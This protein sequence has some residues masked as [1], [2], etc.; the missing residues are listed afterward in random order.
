MSPIANPQFEPPNNDEL[1]AYLDGELPPEEC[2]AVEE[3]L[4]N[5]SS[6][7]QQL[8]DLDQAWE[9]LSSLPPA[10]V[11]DSFA[12]TTIE[13]ACVQ[14]QDDISRQKSLVA[15]ETGSRRRWWIAGGVAAAL[16][17]F[18]MARAIATHRSNM[19]L[20]DLPLIQQ[21]NVLSHVENIAFLRQLAKDVPLAELKKD[22]DD[23][24]FQHDL[25]SFRK[26]NALPLAGRREWVNSL[27]ADEKAALAERSRLFES[28]AQT[29]A[30]RDRWREL[31]HEASRDPQLEET[32]VAYGQW[33]G[34]QSGAQLEQLRENTKDLQTDE[35]VAEVHRMVHDESVQAAKHLSPPDAK[36]LRDEIFAL[37]K[38][39]KSDVLNKIPERERNRVPDFDVSKPAGATFVVR[40]L[41]WDN[42]TRATT[43]DRLLS[44]LSPEARDHWNQLGLGGRMRQLWQWEVDALDPQLGPAELEQFFASDLTP[45]EQQMLL[46][47]PRSEMKSRLQQMYM[48]S[49]LGIDDDRAQFF[50][51]FGEGLRGPGPPNR[52]RPGERGPGPGFDFGPGGP[53][54]PGDPRF[55]RGRPEGE[56]RPDGRR[57][58]RPENRMDDGRRG[59][60]RHRPPDDGPDGPPHG[61][62][63][64][65]PPPDDQHDPP[66]T[67]V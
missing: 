30:D 65:G 48:S 21:A 43:V 8:R 25:E 23:V 31:V 33:L 9:A 40:H 12:R 42:D 10:T 59:E 15:V 17:G 34:R 1:V 60:R 45:T 39:K 57:G 44:K 18:V 37:A 4:A 61:G 56:M 19:L 66:P 27:S 7:R 11:D 26:A 64:P 50:R 63:P 67:G 49:K 41:L 58:P 3:R 29:P 6:Y 62:P 38:E 22:K 13:L 20:A 28:R 47:M 55:D 35:K 54:G 2:R 51:D 52:G 5:D 46:D 36:A 14:A 24:A 16:I 53:P 32:L